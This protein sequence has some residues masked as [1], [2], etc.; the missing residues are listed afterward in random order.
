MY[1][2][3]TQAKCLLALKTTS[4]EPILRPSGQTCNTVQS[5]AVLFPAAPFTHTRTS[6]HAAAADQLQE[7][8]ERAI[9]DLHVW[10]FKE[11][12]CGPLVA[13]IGVLPTAVELATLP[14]LEVA[15]AGLQSVAKRPFRLWQHVTTRSEQVGF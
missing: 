6:L 2:Q 15:G 1:S 9:C 7:L 11:Q 5:V 4:I 12:S 13:D 14:P 10:S 3:N 8:P